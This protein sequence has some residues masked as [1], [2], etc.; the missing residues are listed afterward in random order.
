MVCGDVRCIVISL[1][2]YGV[3]RC[4]LMSGVCCCQ[5]CSDVRCVVMLGVW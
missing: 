1:Y 2:I 4:V 5:V 3:V